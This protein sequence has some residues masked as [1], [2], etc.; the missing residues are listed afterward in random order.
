MAAAR[1][2]GSCSLTGDGEASG[3]GADDSVEGSAKAAEAAADNEAL[4][5]ALSESRR[6]TLEREAWRPLDAPAMWRTAVA[7]EADARANLQYCHALRDAVEA[8]DAHTSAA[9]NDTSNG[10]ADAVATA[11]DEQHEVIDLLRDAKALALQR[12]RSSPSPADGVLP[13]AVHAAQAHALTLATTHRSD[14]VDGVL[15]TR[16]QFVEMYGQALGAER[17]ER[18]RAHTQE[19]RVAPNGM[20]Y[21]QG[22][23][24]AHFRDGGVQ[25]ASAL[26]RSLRAA[27]GH[28]L[29]AQVQWPSAHERRSDPYEGALL[30]YAD[31]VERYGEHAQ[32]VWDTCE[33]HLQER[34]VA[35]DGLVY[36]HQ[37][38]NAYFRDDGHQW[39]LAAQRRACAGRNAVVYLLSGAHGRTYIGFT[40][41]LVRRLAKHNGI[42]R[43]GAVHTAHHRPWH[44]ALVVTGFGTHADALR[45][46]SKWQH[47]EAAT[48][49]PAHKRNAARRALHLRRLEDNLEV[50]QAL[51]TAWHAYEGTALQV[52]FADAAVNSRADC[53]ID[54]AHMQS[55]RAA[56]H[57]QCCQVLGS[58]AQLSREC[59]T[60][61][62][63]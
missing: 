28:V 42:T 25:W 37:E 36:T 26:E 20:L 29:A 30:S 60:A 4:A 14:P 50:L 10:C 6:L 51:R 39:H 44:V 11:I 23:F 31:F 34:R 19:R 22:A 33:Q 16:D 7:V 47:P 35:P 3:S 8:M 61:W 55:V 2:S 45:F 12:S 27:P 38:F 59:L 41:D 15:R 58:I 57:H 13:P 5:W 46:E 1:R 52:W 49:L 62:C 32:R 43:G 54:A 24:E 63:E 9:M 18:V 17:W 40:V 53:G 21:T 48:C 56:E